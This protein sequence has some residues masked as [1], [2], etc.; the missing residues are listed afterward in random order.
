M[1]VFDVQLKQDVVR[2]IALI[3]DGESKSQRPW[4]VKGK[5]TV[6]PPSW[7]PQRPG[8]PAFKVASAPQDELFLM[9]L[10]FML[11]PSSSTSWAWPSA[12]SD[13]ADLRQSIIVAESVVNGHGCQLRLP[14]LQ[15]NTG[16]PGEVVRIANRGRLRI[17][18]AAGCKG[19]RNGVRRNAD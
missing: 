8:P 11:S 2:S 4:V 18:G 17:G 3:D 6:N 13:P 12:E 1:V 14:I 19:C 9:L 7:C 5:S 15:Q 10:S 16:K